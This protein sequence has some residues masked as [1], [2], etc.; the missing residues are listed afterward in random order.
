MTLSQSRNHTVVGSLC[1]SRVS[2]RSV[3]TEG[4]T[5]HQRSWAVSG[6]LRRGWPRHWRRSSCLVL[7]HG[8]CAS[9]FLPPLAPRALPRFLAT[10]EA[11][12]PAGRFF[13]P[14]GHERRSDPDGSP[15]L[16]R[17]HV[18]PFCLQPPAAPATSFVLFTLLSVRGRTPE[19]LA[20]AMEAQGRCPSGVLARA[21]HSA[22]R[23]AGRQGRIEFTLCH[24]IHVTSL[25]TGCSPPAALHPVSPRRSSLRLQASE[26]SA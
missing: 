14:L 4:S 6:L 23:L 1:S 16:S 10:M 19:N 2:M 7:G 21:S 9:T 17:T 8:F 24:V 12:T 3:Q 5:H 11:L 20:S 22:R 26:H 15:C 18:Q 13:G 25:R